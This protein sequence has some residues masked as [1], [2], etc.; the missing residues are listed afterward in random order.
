MIYYECSA[1]CTNNTLLDI[2][3]CGLVTYLFYVYI[4]TIASLKGLKNL[5][6]FRFSICVILIY[7]EYSYSIYCNKNTDYPSILFYDD[8]KGEG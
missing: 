1:L 7:F 3:L 6:M 2:L 8:R 4:K 5:E